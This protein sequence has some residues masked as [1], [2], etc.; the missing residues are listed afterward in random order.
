[1]RRT[2]TGLSAYL[3]IVF[4]A[5]GCNS[6]FM[7]DDL[8]D[9]SEKIKAKDKVDPGPGAGA[10]PIGVWKALACSGKYTILRFNSN[11]TGAFERPDCNGICT[12]LIFNF[13]YT[14]SGSTATLTYTTTEETYCTGYATQRPDVPSPRTF[15]GSFSCSG[16]QLKLNFGTGD[17]VYTK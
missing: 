1:M 15:G 13:K 5:L 8:D 6:D 10:C 16:G 2:F 4:I 14:I 17:Q 9:L 7:Y 12:N 3:I 11:G